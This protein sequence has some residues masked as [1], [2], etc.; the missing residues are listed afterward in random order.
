MKQLRILLAASAALAALGLS[1]VAGA[2]AQS[3]KPLVLSGHQRAF[4]AL[5]DPGIVTLAQ[6]RGC[7]SDVLLTFRL[8]Q[9]HG[10]LSVRT[11]TEVGSLCPGRGFS[12]SEI[13]SAAVFRNF[14]GQFDTS[15]KMQL[16]YDE[17]RALNRE[18]GGQA[19]QPES[20]GLVSGHADRIRSLCLKAKR[21][22]Y[23]PRRDVCSDA[24]TADVDGDGR[25]DLVLLYARLIT[26][27]G[28]S[29]KAYPETLKVVLAG[30]GVAQ[31]RFAPAIPGPGIVAV[32]NVNASPGDELF[33]YGSW[34]SSGAQVEVFSFNAGKLV[35]AAANLQM[36]GD[37]A[38]RFGFNCVRTPRPEIIQRDYSLLGPTIYGR[39]R[40]TAYTFVWDGAALRLAS[41]AITI[42]HGWPGGGAIRPGAG[43]NPLPGYR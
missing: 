26:G 37:S 27:T 29:L 22:G 7:R 20:H 43:C 28:A 14:I 1:T 40:L 11:P 34:I 15:N 13:F 18:T 12:V 19:G 38:D 21:L 42:R 16:P 35:R 41:R 6:S 31:A 39:W 10:R 5:D 8:P 32:G 23:V 25:P 36:G 17:H 24:I 9:S 3:K 4:V 2:G 33:I 30:G